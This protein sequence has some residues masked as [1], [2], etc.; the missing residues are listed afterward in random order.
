MTFSKRP[1]ELVRRCGLGELLVYLLLAVVSTWPLARHCPS[2]LPLGTESSATVPL[3]ITWTIWWN[4]DRA[5]SGC[6]DYWDAPI[7]H[8]TPR[9]FAFSEP[10]PT[11][12][13]VAPII[14][15]TGNRVLAYASLLLL[16]LVLNGYTTFL[17][18]R[19]V[20]LRW[21]AAVFGGAIVELLP[22]VHNEVG[23][24]QLVPLCGIIWTIHAV[25][26]LG[27]RPGLVSAVLTAAAFS[28]TYFSCTYYG[29]FLSVL[30][31]V[32]GGWLLGRQLARLR[33]W[34]ALLAAVALWAVV[35]SPV[36]IVQRR[37]VVEH[38]LRR[39]PDLVNR[40]SAEPADYLATPWPELVE[41]NALRA[42]RQRADF[43]LGPGLLKLVL[44]LIGALAGLR[45]RRFRSWTAF[46]LT[47]LSVAFVL[48]LG[49]QASWRGVGLYPLLMDW[50]PGFAQ[51]RSAFRFA[52][53]VQLMVGLLAALGIH[54]IASAAARCGRSGSRVLVV[55]AAAALGFLAAVEVV[56]ARQA[57]FPVP[58]VE[59]QAGWIGW[60]KTQTPPSCVV[61]CVP[62]PPG[63]RVRDYEPTAM[64][65][66]WGTFHHRK[67]VNGYSGFFPSSYLQL[68][69]AMSRFPDKRGLRLLAASGVSYC[70]VRR[71]SVTRDA[72]ATAPGANQLKLVFADEEAG[73][74]IYQLL[75]EEPAAATEDCSP[76]RKEVASTDENR[77]RRGWQSRFVLGGA[78]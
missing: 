17:L 69:Q 19:D 32:A 71:A 49:P 21:L 77:A 20:G 31:L 35:V 59:K 46:C 1:M 43:K 11:A 7:F 29:L 44:A 75:A 4:A 24:L 56:P 53:F 76:Q 22:L 41:P 72:L 50:Y 63:R 55:S 26:R 51:V 40:L 2:R 16:A 8:P 5:G 48:S 18:L 36:V 65:M 28:V 23:V 52:M 60:L 39:S 61:A 10:M 37:V 74:D 78:R 67:M 62:F 14:W 3:F 12:A 70:V 47:V 45:I 58:P 42:L 38:Q 54:G 33:T 64:W 73:V 9:T 66:Y 34:A 6:Q 68:K 25:Y 27:Q 57:L 15:A 13:I 30:L